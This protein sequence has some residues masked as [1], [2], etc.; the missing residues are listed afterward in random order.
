VRPPACRLFQGCSIHEFQEDDNK[1]KPTCCAYSTYGER[2]AC[3]VLVGNLNEREHLD[4]PGV[5]ERIIL[6]WVLRKWEGAWTGLIWL[7]L[8]TGG[9]HLYEQ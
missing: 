4:G 8:G 1:L 6:K 3:R 5:D 2:T 9:G 7:S